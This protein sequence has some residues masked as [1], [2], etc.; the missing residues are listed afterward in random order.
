VYYSRNSHHIGNEV[1]KAKPELHFIMA[2]V[3]VDEF[4]QA[5]KRLLVCEVAL[6]LL[7]LMPYIIITGDSVN[8]CKMGV[9]CSTC[10]IVSLVLNTFSELE[11]MSFFSPLN[12]LDLLLCDM[13]L[14]VLL[15]EHFRG[16]ILRLKDEVRNLEVVL[17]SLKYFY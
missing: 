8:S 15:K 17:T 12:S 6:V 1:H 9:L 10:N 3:W 11:G 14:L 16:E 13:Q 2:I 4:I 7:V 5:S